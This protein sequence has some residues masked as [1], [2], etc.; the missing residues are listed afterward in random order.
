MMNHPV[1]PIAAQGSTR[2]RKRQ[3][4]KGRRVEPQALL[5]VQALLGGARVRPIC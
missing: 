5:E 4:P 2:Q 3:A 1:I